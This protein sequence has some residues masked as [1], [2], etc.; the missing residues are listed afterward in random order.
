MASS[1]VEVKIP[2]P[3]WNKLKRVCPSRG[4]FQALKQLSNCRNEIEISRVVKERIS[5]RLLPS[6]DRIL[7]GLDMSAPTSSWIGYGSRYS[8]L[9]K[10]SH[11]IWL[12][13]HILWGYVVAKKV[14]TWLAAGLSLSLLLCLPLSLSLFVD[15]PQHISEQQIT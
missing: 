6:H 15:I 1:E 12:Y 7:L 8:E 5:G 11:Y 13:T 9:A 2:N 14:D 3:K 10:Q 4:I